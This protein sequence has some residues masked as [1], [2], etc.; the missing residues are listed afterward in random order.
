MEATVKHSVSYESQITK[1]RINPL[2]SMEGRDVLLGFISMY[3]WRRSGRG[4]PNRY[5]G[6][7]S[8][9]AQTFLQNATILNNAIK[10]K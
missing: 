9:L 6:F 5:V 2:K 4:R 10:M 3:L 1:N 7:C 8:R